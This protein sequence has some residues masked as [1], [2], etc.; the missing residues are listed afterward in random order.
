M[1]IERYLT[2]KASKEDERDEIEIILDQ[3][4]ETSPYSTVTSIEQVIDYPGGTLS[5][6][7]VWKV[8]YEQ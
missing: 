4:M 8:T 7:M 3:I 6:P 1:I 2:I 5:G